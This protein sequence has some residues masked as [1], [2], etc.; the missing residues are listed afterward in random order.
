[1]LFGR[2]GELDR[3]VQRLE[4]RG[5]KEQLSQGVAIMRLSVH[6]TRDERKLYSI[7]C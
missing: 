4:W 2:R 5:W 7:P 3:K 1:M 6:K